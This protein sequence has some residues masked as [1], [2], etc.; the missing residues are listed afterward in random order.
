MEDGQDSAHAFSLLGGS[1][2]AAGGGTTEDTRLDHSLKYTARYE[3]LHVGALYQFA[4]ASGSANSAVQVQLGASLGGASVDAYFFRKYDAI[5]ASALSAAQ[6]AALTPQYSAANSLAATV[7][8]NTSYAF[9]ARYDF[10]LLKLYA[11][12]EHIGFENPRT[13]LVDGFVD[14]GGYLLAVVN[15]KAYTNER[16]LQ[17]FWGGAKWLVTP[18][19]YLAAAYYGYR[20]NSYGSGAGAGCSD[21]SSSACS[22][23]ETG[24]GLLSDYRF[25]RHFD[26][27]LGGVWTEVRDGLANGYLNRA[28]LTSTVGVRFKF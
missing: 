9:M 12:Y 18:R 2:T 4:N 21:S 16:V 14:I 1:R 20:Q 11:G 15:D 17:V 8:D 26:A 3:A 27:Y 6:L 10:A 22:G 24:L 5:S 19:L 13:P 7:S 23:T 25:G 28:T